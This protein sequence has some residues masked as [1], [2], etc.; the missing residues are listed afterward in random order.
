VDVLIISQRL[1]FKFKAPKVVVDHTPAYKDAAEIATAWSQTRT[2]LKDLLGR[3]TAN[4]LKAQNLQTP[5]GWQVN[6]VQV[7]GSFRSISF[8]TRHK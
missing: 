7:H 6:I 2:E 5:G 8:T 4:H 3:F 1:P